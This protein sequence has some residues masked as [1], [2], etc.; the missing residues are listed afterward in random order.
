MKKNLVK[1]LSVLA[2][3]FSNLT[4]FADDYI[5]V[6]KKGNVYDEPNAK[7]IT[8]NQ[9]N[10]EISVI[11][12]MVFKTNEHQP[13]WY[14]VEYS[15]GLHAFIP[16]QIV[17]T[18]FNPIKAGSYKIANN[19]SQTLNISANSDEWTATIGTKTYKGSQ[20]EQIVIFND[21]E[22][23]VAFSLVDVG[24]GPVVITYDNAMTKFF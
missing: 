22:G 21:N 16:E 7:Y 20:I 5:A 8:L 12:G 15:P 2:L 1:I 24:S 17:A 13:G 18:N 3:G 23:N 6:A 10:D 11:P 19:S 14:Q 9:N 4:V